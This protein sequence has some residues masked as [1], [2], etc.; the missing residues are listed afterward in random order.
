MTPKTAGKGTT[1]KHSEHVA[2]RKVAGEAVI[3]DVDTA[4]YYS[5]NGVGL[6]IWELLGERKPEA[7]I[8]DAITS[9]Y[10]APRQRIAED[11]ERLLRRL[12]KEGII[13]P[14]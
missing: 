1:W 4:V 10:D 13:A 9:E 11:L 12:K 14:A 6:R 8:L 7:E 2:W 5:L 3:L